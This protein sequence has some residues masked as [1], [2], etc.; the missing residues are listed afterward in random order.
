MG[1]PLARVQPTEQRIQFHSRCLRPRLEHQGS[2]SLVQSATRRIKTIMRSGQYLQGR[3]HLR[4]KDCDGT[5]RHCCLG[6]L[7][8][9]HSKATG[10][11]WSVGDS[12]WY[13]DENAILP[14]EVAEWAGLGHE[15]AN[16]EVKYGSAGGPWNLAALNDRQRPVSFNELADIIEAQAETMGFPTKL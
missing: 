16:P 5:I 1:H 8:D 4:S 15:R 12:D 7:C 14:K 13:F 11:R 9:L 6:V 10:T 3:G 2:R